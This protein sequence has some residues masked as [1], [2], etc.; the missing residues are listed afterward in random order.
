LLPPILSTLS[1]MSAELEGSLLTAQGELDRAKKVFASAHEQ[2]LRLG[3]HEPPLY[4]RPVA[5]TEGAAMLE[6]GQYEAAKM[7]YQEALD[8]RPKSGFALYGLALAAEKSGD[9]AVSA[10]QFEKFLEV[11]NDADP[12]LLQLKHARATQR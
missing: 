10:S 5:E 7:A 3:Y 8:Q 9:R 11:W 1:I 4:I 12:E 2:E 6:A